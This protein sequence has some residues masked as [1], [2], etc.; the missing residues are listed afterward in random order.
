M[1][2]QDVAILPSRANLAPHFLK[3]VVEDMFCLTATSFKTVVGRRWHATR[4]ILCS[5][6]HLFASVEFD[7]YHKTI[8]NLNQISPRGLFKDNNRFKIVVYYV[9]NCV[10]Y[11][12]ILLYI[13]FFA[14]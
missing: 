6:N 12:T 8:T 1:E 11:D 4:N 13:M 9:L 5:K 7:G 14:C 2:F 3:I 10:L